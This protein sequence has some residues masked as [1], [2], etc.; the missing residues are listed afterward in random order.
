MKPS[1]ENIQHITTKN[2]IIGFIGSLLLTLGSY[3]LVTN[4]VF[5]ARV[6]FFVIIVF[7]LEQ[8]ILQVF[9][10][11]HLGQ[12]K[13][14]KFNTAIFLYMAMTVIVIVIGT[15]WIMYNLDYNHANHDMSPEETEKH[16]LE[17][18]NIHKH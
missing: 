15:M 17:E 8:F 6:T 3:L 4:E 10:F 9:L 14:P 16:L 18:E 1:Q 13:K 12:E 11:L 5:S 2:Y 7:A